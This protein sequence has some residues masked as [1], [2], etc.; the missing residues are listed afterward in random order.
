MSPNRLN[1]NF[2]AIL[3]SGHYL[4][5]R[6]IKCFLFYLVQCHG[7]KIII[8]LILW[9]SSCEQKQASVFLIDVYNITR[10]VY[11]LA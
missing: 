3:S 9:V 7:K 4:L 6:I 8:M 2:V 10:T 11:V 5:P 1:F